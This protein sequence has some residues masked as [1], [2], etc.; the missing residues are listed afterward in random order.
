MHSLSV[1]HIQTQRYHTFSNLGGG[2]VVSIFN[3][4]ILNS[5]FGNVLR[6]QRTNCYLCSLDDNGAL[7]FKNGSLT[8]LP[9][10]PLWIH[11]P[12]TFFFFFF[13]PVFLQ[14]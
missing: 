6:K 14:V 7:L 4:Y 11:D 13:F 3:N 12:A 5:L 8:F 10:V 9:L 1:Y 2:P